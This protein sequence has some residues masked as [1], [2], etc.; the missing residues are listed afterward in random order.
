MQQRNN[1]GN[2][3]F[4]KTCNRTR[5]AKGKARKSA[6]AAGKRTRNVVA[7]HAS[8]HVLAIA[9]QSIWIWLQLTMSSTTTMLRL[10]GFGYFCRFKISD[11][12]TFESLFFPDKDGLMKRLNDFQN[13][14]GGYARPGVPHKLGVLLHGPPG[15]CA[16]YTE[17]RR[18]L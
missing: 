10:R 13:K 15:K 17:K 6:L 18:V 5:G 12:R 8:N 16:L 1:R 14:A 7:S 11:G 9:E 4:C 3:R 2:N